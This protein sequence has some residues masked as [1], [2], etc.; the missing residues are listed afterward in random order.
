MSAT[1][2]NADLR[3]IQFVLFEQLKIQDDMAGFE[4]LEDW[5][6]DMYKSVLESALEMSTEKLW[7]SNGRGD[8]EGCTLDGEG[9]VT[10]PECY[11]GA[12]QAMCEG[13]WIG[14]TAPM[15]YGG[16]GLRSTAA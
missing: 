8:S 3:D 9:N 4:G 16:V 1:G 2:F 7:P 6:Q 12:W 10:I 11:E 13:G 14:L 15:E 5:D